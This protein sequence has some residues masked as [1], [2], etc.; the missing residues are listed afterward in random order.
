MTL[1]RVFKSSSVSA[2]S[3]LSSA[4][5]RLLIRISFMLISTLMP[6]K[7]FL[8]ICSEYKL[9]K[10]DDRKHPCLTPRWIAMSSVF[11][12]NTNT[13]AFWLQYNLLSNW[14]L[15]GLGSDQSL[16]RLVYY[17]VLCQRLFSILRTPYIRPCRHPDI[18]VS[19]D[20]SR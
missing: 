19:S 15:Q 14:Y 5:R 10:S 12:D 18:I 8:K 2:S 16:F 9:N 11:F 4:Y 17:D 3:K 6:S 13:S 20:S 7:A 1:N